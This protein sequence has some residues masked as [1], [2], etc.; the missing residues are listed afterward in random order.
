MRRLKHQLQRFNSF[1]MH[2][3]YLNWDLYVPHV[4]FSFWSINGG[5]QMLFSCIIV[6]FV[7][8]FH[9]LLKPTTE[10][11]VPVAL[12][13]FG[14]EDSE[15]AEQS[16]LSQVCWYCIKIYVSY[17]IMLIVMTFNMFLIISVIFGYAIGMLYKNAYI[18]TTM[19]FPPSS[20]LQL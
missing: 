9:E 3:D 5:I 18:S 7:S 14:A 12:S 2:K 11:A 13:L 19:A 10:N 17:I 15:L 20:A 8:F 16:L 1:I 4:L 6:G